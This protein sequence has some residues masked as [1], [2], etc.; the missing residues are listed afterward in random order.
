MIRSDEL[1]AAHAVLTAVML[2]DEPGAGKSMFLSPHSTSSSS[3]D[4]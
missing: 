2:A 1:S 3:Q 4:A